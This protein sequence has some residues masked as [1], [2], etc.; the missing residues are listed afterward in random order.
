MRIDVD[1]IKIMELAGYKPEELHADVEQNG[2]EEE[3]PD[4]EIASLESEIVGCS[5]NSYF[6]EFAHIALSSPDLVEKLSSEKEDGKHVSQLE[7]EWV[8]KC[9]FGPA[10]TDLLFELTQRFCRDRLFFEALCRYLVLEPDR[11]MVDKVLCP[12]LRRAIDGHIDQHLSSTIA[13]ETGASQARTQRALIE[14]SLD[15]RLIP[16]E[17]LGRAGWK[18]SVAEFEE[19]LNSSDFW[20]ELK[21]CDPA[22]DCHFERIKEKAREATEQLILSNLRLVVSIVKKYVSIGLPLAD[23]IQEGNVGL[24]QA[25][26]RFDYRRG[27]KFSTYA[28]WWIRHAALQA[29][30]DQSR[31]VRLPVHASDAVVRLAKAEQRLYQELSRKPTTKEIAFE[32]RV[33]PEKVEQL[34]RVSLSGSISLETAVG[35]E[36]GRLSDFIEDRMSP[37]PIE[38]ATAVLLSEQLSAALVVLSPRE[39]RVIEMRFGL[40]GELMRKL[41]EVGKELGISGERVRQIEERAL[42]KL[43]CSR[44]FRELIRYL[45]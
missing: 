3:P 8:A 12:E 9:W 7:Q 26:E 6:A 35:E 22:I 33:S 38:K 17:I 13:G 18:C 34:L 40:G 25:V 29:V 24:M 5:L 27:Y 4:V 31:T 44:D 43:R 16:W 39:L 37:N 21:E 23:L 19:V 11:S 10:A 14:L 15:S 28:Y 45:R 30:A 20:D 36:G 41:D 32:M 1:K 42:C 2:C